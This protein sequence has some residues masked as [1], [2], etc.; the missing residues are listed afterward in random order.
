METRDRKGAR[1]QSILSS[2]RLCV[3]AILSLSLSGCTTTLSEQDCERYRD[4]LVAWAAAKGVDKKD[5]AD[6]FMKSCPGTT[7]SKSTKK[8]LEGAT[9]DVAFQK[10]LE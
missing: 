10:C 3:F 2:L 6:T 7:I 9:D 8:C 1:A 4:K 5:E